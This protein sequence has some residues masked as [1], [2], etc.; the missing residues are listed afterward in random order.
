M[1]ILLL[2]INAFTSPL[3]SD[4]ALFNFIYQKD[5]LELKQQQHRLTFISAAAVGE[6][7]YVCTGQ[8][9]RVFNG[10]LTWACGIVC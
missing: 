10:G 3:L 1:C 4:D 7:F 6:V 5:R 2:S 9:E 8:S